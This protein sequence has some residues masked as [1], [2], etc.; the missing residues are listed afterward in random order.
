MLMHVG[1]QLYMNMIINLTIIT[2]GEAIS[3]Y[4]FNK[5]NDGAN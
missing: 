4:K 1:L 2:N 3:W 5:F